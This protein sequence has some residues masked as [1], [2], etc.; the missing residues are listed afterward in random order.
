MLLMTG[1]SD[2]HSINGPD[3]APV[4]TATETHDLLTAFDQVG[5]DSDAA[6]TAGK[7]LTQSCQQGG[8]VMGTAT[9]PTATDPYSMDLSLMFR[10]CKVTSDAG[11]TWTLDSDAPLRFTQSSRSDAATKTIRVTV[12]LNGNLHFASNGTSGM[13]PI[14]VKIT[15]IYRDDLTFLSGGEI[16]GTYCGHSALQVL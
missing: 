11:R 1:C 16:T 2:K 8:T 7:P 5:F 12:T 13:C 10:G 14:D 3:A 9:W 15:S 6:A 4:L